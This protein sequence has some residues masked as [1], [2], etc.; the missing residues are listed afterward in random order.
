M[1]CTSKRDGGNDGRL[2][3]GGR[4]SSCAKAR[5]EAPLKLKR[6]NEPSW[7]ASWLIHTIG[8]FLVWHSVGQLLIQKGLLGCISTDCYRVTVIITVIV[9]AT[10]MSRS[11]H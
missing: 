3:A 11:T 1:L 7:L 4:G 10:L 8:H 6:F 2:P 5:K 9:A